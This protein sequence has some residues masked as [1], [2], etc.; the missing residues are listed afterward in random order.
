MRRIKVLMIY[1]EMPTVG[2]R[3][4]PLGFYTA[5]TIL[6]DNDFDVE[7]LD[8][9]F[10]SDYISAITTNI[11]QYS[12]DL[13][14]FSIC[15]AKNYK[16]AIDIIENMELHK[17][18]KIFMGG[19]HMHAPMSSNSGLYVPI[20]GDLEA[21]EYFYD[22]KIVCQKSP[23]SINYSLVKHPN[24]YYPALEVSR[25]CWNRCKF[26]N[27]NNTFFEKDCRKIEDELKALSILY[28]RGS[29]LTLAGS[30]HLFKN[31]IKYGLIDILLDYREHFNFSF[32]LGV[33]S[34]WSDV[35][36]YILRL[37]PWN[38]FVGIDSCDEQTL[39]RMNKSYQPTLYIQKASELLD[40]CKKDGI[41]TFATYIYGY[42]GNTIKDIDKLDG[43]F[44][45][46]ACENIIQIGFPCEAYPGTELLL[47]RTYYE[48]QGV[49]Y[50]RVYPN[51][52]IE[53]YK[54]DISQELKHNHLV[55]RS[56]CIYD[57]VNTKDMYVISR[58]KG[59]SL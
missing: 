21:I 22:R 8:L 25:G 28:P 17:Q 42:P 29:I 15:S 56:K 58:C 35:W 59:K 51:T 12:P 55:Y 31:W 2:I 14:G 54:L 23:T 10:H 48:R 47:N 7:C 5:A 39:I 24:L 13:L 52:M 45:E 26:C 33:E 37:N 18:Y 16:L 1:P 53:Y 9:S 19:Q 38:I 3:S 30:N 20:V 6:C 43:F 4:F 27:S 44:I 50:N 41:Y 49:V 36:D 57:S 40:R 34:S 46:H 32:N 11:Q